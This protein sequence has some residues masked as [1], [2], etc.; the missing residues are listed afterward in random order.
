MGRSTVPSLPPQLVFPGWSYSQI[1]LLA[2]SADQGSLTK[3]ATM[4]RWS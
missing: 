3:D 4:A 1:I 2:V